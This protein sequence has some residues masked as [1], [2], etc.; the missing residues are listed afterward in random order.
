MTVTALFGL[1]FTI[2]FFLCSLLSWCPWWQLW[3]SIYCCLLCAILRCAISTNCVQFQCYNQCFHISNHRYWIFFSTDDVVIQDVPLSLPTNVVE[4]SARASFSVV[5]KYM[6][7]KTWKETKCKN[8]KWKIFQDSKCEFPPI[9]WKLLS[10]ETDSH[11]GQEC[12]LLYQR[13]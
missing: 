7:N 2:L 8:M 5:G 13:N 4:G 10:K 1:V 11:L 6:I 3:I 12:S 9:S